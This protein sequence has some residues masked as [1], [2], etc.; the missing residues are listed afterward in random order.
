[1]G[2]QQSSLFAFPKANSPFCSLPFFFFGQYPGGFL[3]ESKRARSRSQS[4]RLF[5]VKLALYYNADF[6]ELEEIT[7]RALLEVETEAP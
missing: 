4:M 5:L 3:I 7:K 6:H 1:M 2:N